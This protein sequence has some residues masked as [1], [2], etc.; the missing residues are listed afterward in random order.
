[1]T[2]SVVDQLE[3]VHVQNKERP[4]LSRHH[5]LQ[6][7]GDQFLGSPP[8]VDAGEGVLLCHAP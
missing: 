6:L 2:V 7:L 8:V 4:H 1:M 5:T 3:V